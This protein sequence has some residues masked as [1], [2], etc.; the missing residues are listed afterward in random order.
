MDKNFQFDFWLREHSFRDTSHPVVRFFSQQRMQLV[1]DCIPFDKIRTYL[2]IG[3]G[4]GVSVLYLPE[5]LKVCVSDYAINRLEKN[6]FSAK[7]V[8]DC[9]MLPFKDNSFDVV[10]CWEVLHHN[11]DIQKVIAEM[12]R[13]SKKYIYIFEPNVRN[14]LQFVFALLS[15][16][17]RW[18]IKYKYTLKNLKAQFV[19]AGLK[20]KIAQNIGWIF[21]N[22]TTLW[23]LG[24]LRRL[25][26]NHA[27]AISNFLVFEKDDKKSR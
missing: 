7:V 15:K 23:L 19:K 24:F 16:E 11:P 25:P 21:P 14:P 8:C 18:V 9:N 5:N 2:D 13:I 6:R 12:K 26:F 20:T 22:K 17:H 4:D 27:L 10:S 1:K 3:S